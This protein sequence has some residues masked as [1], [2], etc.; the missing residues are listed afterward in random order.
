MPGR[1]IL[2]LSREDADFRLCSAFQL[3]SWRGFTRLTIG[4]HSLRSGFVTTAGR[5]GVGLADAMA[6]SGHRGMATALGYHQAGAVL[7]NPAAWLA[8]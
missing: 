4:G 6:L 3:R 5:R 8:D 2:H 1:E 7:T